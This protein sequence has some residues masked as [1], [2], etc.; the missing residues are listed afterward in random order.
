MADIAT[1]RSVSGEMMTG[2]LARGRVN[3]PPL[4]IIDADY[5]EVMPEPRATKAARRPAAE[6][7]AQQAGLST[8]SREPVRVGTKRSSRGGPLF[9][10]VGGLAVIG[11]FWISGGHSI[12]REKLFLGAE[13]PAAKLEISN[14]RSSNVTVDGAQALI[15]DGDIRND[16][17]A[18]GQAPSLVIQV[19]SVNGQ[20]TLYRLGTL[21]T[22][23]A[24]GAKYS[25]SSRLDM[26]KDGVKT[27]SVTFDE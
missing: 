17:Q 27:V 4:D 25:F 18:S 5:I 19:L 26:P 22:P 8:L 9:W 3:A 11:A 7:T 1:A 16:G 14:V 23:L 24:P 12:V 6:P 10:L 21:R 13:A 15:V 2:G 20:A